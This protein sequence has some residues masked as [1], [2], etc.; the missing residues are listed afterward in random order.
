MSSSQEFSLLLRLWR[1]CGARCTVVQYTEHVPQQRGWHGTSRSVI[2]SSEVRRSTACS[3]RSFS[4]G[5]LTL[6]LPLLAFEG[7]SSAVLLGPLRMEDTALLRRMGG[8]S[9]RGDISRRSFRR[10]IARERLLGDVVVNIVFDLGGVVVT[11]EPEAII[12]QVFADPTMQALVHTEIFRHADWLALD[13]GTLPWQEAVR[14]GAQRTGLSEA[15]VAA[16]LSRCHRRWSRSPGPWT[17]CIA[18]RPT[19]TRCSACRICM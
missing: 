19:G 1:C 2:W 8:E 10:P 14:R 16:L 12:A 3:A 15:E 5:C 9:A 7:R 6:L 4:L 13:R 11:W 18:S 17:C